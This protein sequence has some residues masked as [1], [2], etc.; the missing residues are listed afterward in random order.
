M[1]RFDHT[2]SV[3]RKA[4]LAMNTAKIINEQLENKEITE[5]EAISAMIKWAVN[6]N[7]KSFW[8]DIDDLLR[9]KYETEKWF[10]LVRRLR[11]T[12]NEW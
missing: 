6:S 5:E 4:P 2:K 9:K 1:S 3:T 8:F 7:C 12:K 10:W 11:N